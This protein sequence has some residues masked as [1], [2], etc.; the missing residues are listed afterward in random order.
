MSWTDK[1]WDIVDTFYWTPDYIGLKSIPKSQTK[2]EGET[3][4]VPKSMTNTNGPLY[5]RLR[6]GVQF[7]DYVRRQEEIVNQIFD[8]TFG[9]AA[10]NVVS[11]VLGKLAGLPASENFSSLGLETRYRYGWGEHR[12]VTQHDGFF[13]GQD[14]NLAVELKFNAK[15]SPDQLAKY[16]F[17]LLS[18][19]K[20]SKKTLAPHLLFIMN[21]PPKNALTMQ[22]GIN[23]GDI[24]AQHSDFLIGSLRN[25]IVKD[26]LE[27]NR[28]A[29]RDILDR[30]NVSGCT[31]ADLVEQ[32]DNYVSGLT[33]SDGDKT[34]ANL[35]VGFSGEIRKHPLSNI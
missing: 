31:W 35:L 32:L 1:Y 34:L 25:K 24:G 17:L 16:C 23:P 13:V 6:K 12:N 21:E 7:R 27:Q 3:V 19:E 30:I 28:D 20:Y 29:F 22:L 15:S 33:D 8:L 11:D 10:G 18:E 14:T 9:V 26:F 2:D 4:R 5:R